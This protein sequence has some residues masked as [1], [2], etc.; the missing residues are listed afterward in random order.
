MTYEFF[1]FDDPP[2]AEQVER[3]LFAAFDGVSR[4][5]GISWHEA[6]AIDDYEIGM[7]REEARELDTDRCWQ[8]LLDDPGE[9][10]ENMIVFCF[11]DFIGVR[12]YLAPLLIR[13]LR[14]GTPP[15]T[16]A[17]TRWLNDPTPFTLKQRIA[18][19][20]Y[21]MWAAVADVTPFHFHTGEWFVTLDEDW[22]PYVNADQS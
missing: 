7:T 8:D 21:M 11:G 14:R 15:S 10:L 9:H 4:D 17:L 19:A 3:D 12:Y 1:T 20:R 22:M 2:L 18:L 16:L 5:G 13:S 6:D